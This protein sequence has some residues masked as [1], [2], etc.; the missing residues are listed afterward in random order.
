MNVEQLLNEGG[1]L[2]VTRTVCA[3]A[4]LILFL[5]SHLILIVAVNA[6]T[7]EAHAQ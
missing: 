3:I 4:Q 7:E 5:A 2:C 6:L 1:I